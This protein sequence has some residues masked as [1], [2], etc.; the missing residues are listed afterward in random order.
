MD[1]STHQNL[2]KN[3]Q[4][5]PDLSIENVEEGSCSKFLQTLVKIRQLFGEKL[6]IRQVPNVPK[7][8]QDFN[9]GFKEVKVGF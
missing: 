5:V 4:W 6:V 8:I 2:E 3:R 9:E 7:A 1:D